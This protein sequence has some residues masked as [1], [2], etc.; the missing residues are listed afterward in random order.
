MIKWE[1]KIYQNDK[2]HFGLLAFTK[3]EPDSGNN[4]KSNNKINHNIARIIN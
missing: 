3:C 2:L 1:W 4:I